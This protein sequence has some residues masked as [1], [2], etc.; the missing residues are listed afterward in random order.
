MNEVPLFVGI[1]VSKDHLDLAVRPAGEAWQVSHD[2]QGINSLTE[3]LRELAPRL[4]VVEATGG[5]EMALTGE[6]AAAGLPVAVVNPRHVRDFAR[7]AGQL[8]KTDSLDAHVLAHFAEAMQPKP[9]DLPDASAQELRAL[10]ARRRQ[11]V[12]MTTAEKN[13]MR[14]AT[15]R[16]RTKVQEHVRWLEDS[17]KELDKDLA[18]SIRSSPMWRTKEK[19][20]RSTPGVGPILSMTL[21]SDLPELG[22]LNRGEI[23]ALVGVAPFNRDSGT[24]RGK[25]KVWGGRS[26]VRAVLYMA[27]L[28]ATRFNPVLRDFY[29]RLCAAGKPKKVAI[30]ACMRKLLTILNVMVK[31]NRHWN[32]VVQN[33]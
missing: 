9:R 13:R 14:T 20:L 33:S 18:D 11:L 25:R 22:V 16:V 21:L 32:H 29:Q 31:H 1:D 4:V 15:P 27:T 10:V 17:L 30:T 5:M 28:V 23:A 6:L 26:Q 8:A 19:L 3:R 24:L 12:E 7:A 2:P